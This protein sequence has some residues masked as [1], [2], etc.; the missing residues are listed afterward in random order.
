MLFLFNYS[1]WTFMIKAHSLPRQNLTYSAVSLVNS[2]ATQMKFCGSHDSVVYRGGCGW[3]NGHG[4][5]AWGA[6]NDKLEKFSKMVFMVNDFLRK[7]RQKFWETNQKMINF[8]ENVEFPKKCREFPYPGHSRTSLARAYK[9]CCTPCR[10]YA[11]EIPRL[12]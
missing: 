1:I 10:C 2:A 6:S 12:D 7:G 8:S 9:N 4:R 11:G 5:P 3:C